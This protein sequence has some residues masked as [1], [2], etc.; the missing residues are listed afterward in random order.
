MEQE[1]FQNNNNDNL[2]K[3][4]RSGSVLKWA[5]VVGIVI[6]LNLFFVYVIKVF[7]SEPEYK[8]FCEEKQVRII[9]DTKN[10]C[11]AIGGQWTDDKYIQKTIPR[12]GSVEIPV[13]KTESKGYCNS[14]FTCGQEY[15]DA[16]DIYGRNVFIVWVSVGVV[17]IIGSLF[18]ASITAVSLGFSLGGVLA[19][20]IGTTRY[21]STMDDY[22]RVIILAIALIALIWIGIKKIK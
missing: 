11:L 22:L 10:E 5:L 13:I 8:N 6:V 14:D 15:R 2:D 20:I 12:D 17:S 3:S 18:I 7:Y 19:L 4:T 16:R 21:W 1:N 9:P